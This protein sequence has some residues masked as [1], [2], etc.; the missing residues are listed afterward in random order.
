MKRCLLRTAAAI[1]IVAAPAALVLA[2]VTPQ[3]IEVDDLRGK[4]SIEE[5]TTS[6]YTQGASI[7][8]TNCAAYAGSTTNAARQDL[9]AVTAELLISSASSGGSVETNAVTA[10]NATNGTWWAAGTVPASDP[11]YWQLR[12]TDA[13]TNIYYYL[14]EKIPTQDHL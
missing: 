12:L 9:T 2:G 14:Q 7:L 10:I 13:N 3:S 11:M 5:T 1:C 4:T 8:F 6:K